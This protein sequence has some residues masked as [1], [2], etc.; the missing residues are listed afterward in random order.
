[1]SSSQWVMFT[2]SK[3]CYS[4][5]SNSFKNIGQ[6]IMRPSLQHNSRRSLPKCAKTRHVVIDTRKTLR[7]DATENRLKG[8]WILQSALTHGWMD[9]GFTYCSSKRRPPCCECR[10]FYQDVLWRTLSGRHHTALRST[11]TGHSS[12]PQSDSTILIPVIIIIIIITHW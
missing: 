6:V 8:S 9:S 3:L 1:M 4:T 10:L 5:C 11:R 12:A 7:L 2:L